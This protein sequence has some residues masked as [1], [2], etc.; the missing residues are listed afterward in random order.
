M[1]Q[2]LLESLLRRMIGEYVEDL[3]KRALNVSV[4]SGEVDLHDLKFKKDV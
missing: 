2:G 3:D 1:F 4:Y